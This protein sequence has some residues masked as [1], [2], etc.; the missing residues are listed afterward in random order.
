MAVLARPGWEVDDHVEQLRKWRDTVLPD[1]VIY[2]W[3]INDMELDNSL[4]PRANWIW[5]RI[6]LHKYLVRWSYLWFFLDYS[7]TNLW[8]PGSSY[9]SYLSEQYSEGSSKWTEF[10]D[11]FTEWCSLALETTPRVLVALYPQMDLP[12]GAP[13]AFTDIGQ[14]FSRR[15]SSLCAEVMYLDLTSAF[16]RF[17]DAQD[18]KATRFDRHPGVAAHAEMAKEILEALQQQWPELFSLDRP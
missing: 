17:D 5:R 15:V 14:D 16:S 2:Q 13:P 18:L 6:F 11:F 4:R 3:T 8:S 9:S 12:N 10:S 7:A 1:V